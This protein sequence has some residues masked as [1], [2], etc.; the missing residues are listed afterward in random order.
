M[1]MV[2]TGG[3]EG[4]KWEDGGERWTV[5]VSEAVNSTSSHWVAQQAVSVD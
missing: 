5:H 1:A 4:A 3:E 2:V